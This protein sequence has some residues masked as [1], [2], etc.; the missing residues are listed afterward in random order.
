MMNL[1]APIRSWW[2]AI[3]HRSRADEDVAAELQFHIDAH[4]EHLIASG[5][6]PAEA[7]RRAKIEFG[8]VDVQKEKYRAAIGLRP[9][10]EIGGDLRY[11]LRSLWRN[12]SV[13][14]AAILSLALGIGATSAMFNAIYSTLLH[15]FPYADADRIVNP[16]LID[17]KQP[18]VPTWFAL[19]PA[20]YESFIKAQSIDSVLGF[21][22]QGQQETGQQF[23]EDVSV[24]FV[25]PNMNDFLGVPAMLGRGM[26]L[27]DGKQDVIVLGY[28]YWQRRFGGDRAVI[29]HTLNLDNTVFTIIGVMPPRFTFTETVGNVDAY[30]PWNAKRAPALLPWIKLRR[31]VTPEAA[32]AD[33][34]PYLNRFKQESPM[35]FPKEFHVDVQPIA[36][37]YM[38]RTGRTLALLF[39][40][41]V[42]LLLIGCANCSVLL[43]AR[44]EARQHELSIRSAIGAG[45]FRLIRQLLIE[46][47]AI[48][49]AGA[50]LGTL[51]AYWLARLPLKLMP[52]VFPQE[53]TITMN[54]PVLGFSIA[55]ALLT[56]VLFGLAPA[57]RFSR[58]DVSHMMQTRS[59]TISASGGRSL[60]LLIGAQIALTF[61]LMGV[62]AAAITGFMHITSMNL[63]YDPHH[64]GFLGIPLKQAPTKNREATASYIARLRDTIAA[65]PGVLSV[66]VASSGIP[67]SQPFGGFGTP[68][69]FELLGHTADSAQQALV[70]LVSPEYFATLKIPLLSGRLWTRDENRQGDFVAVVNQ[71]FAQRYL[72]DRN[73]VGQQLRTDAVKDDG[74]PASMA[75]PNSTDWRQILGV[76]ADHRNNGLERP[77]APAIY[78]PYTTFMWNATQLFIRTA[79]PPETMLQPLRRAIHVFNPEQR[80]GGNH[81]GTLEDSLSVQTIWIQQHTFSVLFSFFGA[82]AL[83]LSLFGI[84][85]TIFFATAR[86]QNELGIRMAL[87]A[88]RGH[89]MWTV[90][91][92]TLLTISVGILA[93]LLANLYLR[94]LLQ[95]WMP[96]NNHSP[97][98][99][100]PVV[101]VLILGSSVSCLLPAVRAAHADPMATLRSE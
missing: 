10:H 87:G 40:S 90:S 56:G 1:F 41:V 4:T 61:I 97:W 54:W 53:A 47:F 60:N 23:P 65:V 28:K 35:H 44:G 62:A 29:G 52:G 25:T 32:D 80:I 73:P 30:I 42:F 89:I 22:V 31:G 13:S 9:F 67:P 51:L 5:L 78:V 14:L 45:R 94:G 2:R 46:S 11:G 98:L 74:R 18:L 49:F 96:G 85:S 69:S 63:G 76:V 71:T 38:H 59:R 12:P 20:Q 84:A 79:A 75:S 7:A 81:I 8:R 70:Q 36:A 27:S 26:R 99:L 86:R 19:E 95:K 68:A 6:S 101:A 17:E 92:S 66:G 50:A 72:A 3:A 15:P 48:A 82:L 24:A 57:L 43:L 83:F 39:V 34:Q 58:P 21:L 55:L 16:S 88:R 37:P 100:L 33:F 93:G 64:V 91:R 77:V